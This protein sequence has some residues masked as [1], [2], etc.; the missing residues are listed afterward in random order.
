MTIEC[1][2]DTCKH[3]CINSGD[4]RDEGPFC[5]ERECVKPRIPPNVTWT[6]GNISLTSDLIFGI[7]VLSEDGWVPISE[8]DEDDLAIVRLL[9]GNNP[10]CP[11]RI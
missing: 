4:P 5:Y 1:Y 3:H 10:S 8:L 11:F 7:S 6:N 2:D 9:V